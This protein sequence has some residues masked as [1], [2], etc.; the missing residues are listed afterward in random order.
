MRGKA[1]RGKAD[2]PVDI[3]LNLPGRPADIPQL[4]VCAVSAGVAGNVPGWRLQGL[5][6]RIFL[7]KGLYGY[8][9]HD[10]CLQGAVRVIRGRLGNL[11][12]QVHPLCDLPE[13]RIGSI[14]MRGVLVHDEKLGSG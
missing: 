5:W 13:G 4:T 11:V 10:L 3:R 2:K 6:I 14:Q 9:F 8:L 12:Y 1:Q 7:P